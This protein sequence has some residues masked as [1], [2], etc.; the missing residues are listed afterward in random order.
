MLMDDLDRELS[1]LLCTK[2]G[3]LM[4]DQSARA[5]TSGAHSDNEQ[6]VIV[7]ELGHA[8][9]KIATLAAAVRS[10]AE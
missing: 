3:I 8:S 5:L 6:K 9:V 4:E 10:I 1:K 7:E 2:I